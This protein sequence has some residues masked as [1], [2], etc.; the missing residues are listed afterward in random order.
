LLASCHSTDLF[1]HLSQ[2]SALNDSSCPIS[3]CLY[4]FL[5]TMYFSYV[6]T[7]KLCLISK[8]NSLMGL[9]GSD[10]SLL[11]MRLDYK[12]FEDSAGYF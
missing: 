9:L 7:S 3:L 12:V 2:A 10:T 1:T 11:S 6:K 8:S 4:H 5:L